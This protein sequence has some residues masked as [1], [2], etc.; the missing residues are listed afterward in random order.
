M[1]ERIG[2]VAREAARKS[3]AAA[4]MDVLASF[5]QPQGEAPGEGRSRPGGWG[6]GEAGVRAGAMTS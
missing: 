6:G 5:R 2:G 3:R 4:V 1:V